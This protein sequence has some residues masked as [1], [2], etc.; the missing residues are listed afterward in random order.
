MRT[1]LRNVCILIMIG[2]FLSTRIFAG[3]TG[4]IVGQVVDASTGEPLPGVNILI[5]NTMLGAATDV[6]GTYMILNVPPGIYTLRA[7]IIGYRDMVVSNVRV[8][9][10]KTTRIDFRLQ[11][12]TLQLGETI[13]VTAERP[14]VRKDLTSTESSVG[15][16]VIKSLPVENFSD[17]VNLQAGVIDGHFRGGR[18]GEVAYMVDGVPVN[19][20]YTGSFGVEVENN[21]IQEVSVIS[22][23]FN[24]EYGQA[25]SGVVN[26]VTKEGS[27]H[28]TG[29]GTLYLGDYVSKHDD[30]FWNI[31]R[32]NPIS[33]FQGTVSGPVPGL[34]KRFTFFASARFFKSDGYIY[35][36]EVFLP[37][38]SSDFSPENP[39]DRI[40]ESHGKKYPFSEA[41]AQKLIKDAKAVPMNNAQRFTGS[42]KLTY[43]LTN[44]DKLN[45]QGIAQRREWRE[46]DHRFRLNPDGDYKRFQ[47]SL[48]SVFHWNHVFSAST[49]SDLRYSYFYTRYNQYVYEDVFDPRYVPS[50]RLQL[51]GANAFLVGGQQMWHFNRS[52]MTHLFKLDVTSQV[53]H[54]HQLKGGAEARRH[55]LW[56]HEFEVIPEDPH[57]IAPL[58]SFNN[59]RYLHHPL[60]FSAYLQDK[61]EF[62]FMVVNAGVRF[63]YFDPDGR[64]P[65]DFTRPSQS[66]LKKAGVSW[67]VSPR[68]GIAY[69]ISEKGVVHVSYGHFF[70]I[71]N[72]FYLYTNPE[73][74][75]FPLQSTPSPPPQSLLNT[76]GN[77]ELKPQKTVIYELGFQQQLGAV[78]GLTVTT[79][80][81]DIRN[82]LGTQVLETLQGIKYARYINRDYGFV[83]GITLEFEKKY[84]AGIQAS[85]DYTYQIAKGN[86]SDP[87][88]AFLDAQSD[89]PKETEKE[90]VPLNWDRRHQVNATLTL[91]TPGKMV[92]STIF[93][94]GTGLPY[95]PTFQNVQTAVEN[96]ARKPDQFTV[97]VYFYKD[98]HWL[99]MKYTFFIRAYNVFDRLN[100]RDVF[101]DTGRAGYTLAPLYVGGLRPRGINTLEEYFIRP[102]FYSEP[103]RVQLGLELGF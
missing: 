29:N 87:N 17:V 93:R 11:Q 6:D 1:F 2:F 49:F 39:A 35:G 59:N 44:T 21:T 89:P 38:D 85:I 101:S 72:F 10:D 13:E 86:A 68:F 92:L 15:S 90:L 30:I 43:H 48:T 5:E 40:I 103:R 41:L 7:N 16:D 50:Q 97:D 31:N 99:G 32:P 98:F 66:K 95:T 96:S 53:T 18:L 76:V 26:V 33:N 25:M 81:K 45:I 12:T 42:L 19:D 27:D 37:T 14:M 20:V 55:R 3:T 71:P 23:T 82:L 70:Q 75:I 28:F 94:Y 36:K 54:N 34:G 47:R 52:T 9:V 64:V 100:E 57:R 88:T 58:T 22:G 91:G 63:D 74:D 84:S 56:L 4:K 8:N 83:R 61:M 46:Y 62:T 77:A 69:P 65:E 60:E 51:A 79:F 80:Y 102:D 24:A 67:Q 73:F 78:F